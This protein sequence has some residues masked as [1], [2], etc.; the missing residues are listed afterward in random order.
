MKSIT[1]FP[2]RELYIWLISFAVANLLNVFS[3]LYYK[4][5]WKEL[6]T[7]WGFVLALSLVMYVLYTLVRIIISLIK[8]KKQV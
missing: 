5:Q 8:Q 2:R 6:Y 3:I 1:F 4:T 7:Q